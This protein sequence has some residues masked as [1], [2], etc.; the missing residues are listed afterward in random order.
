[1]FDFKDN[2]G[3]YIAVTHRHMVR[4]IAKKLEPFGIGAGQ[5]PFIFALY[6]QDGQAQQSLAD[7]TA[8]DKAAA[9]RTIGK[10]EAAGYVRRE[11]HGKDGRSFKVF[12][13]PKAR[14]IR[15]KLEAAVL[16]ILDE[17][18]KG[19]GSR[20]RAQAKELLSRMISNISG[21]K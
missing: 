7:R 10:L 8:V 6:I 9:A 17:L 13:T 4:R 18:Q 15:R 5:Y 2:I 1:M 21:S 12:L 19:F 16:E 20:E 11:K 3:R 14:R